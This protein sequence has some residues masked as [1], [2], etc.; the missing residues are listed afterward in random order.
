MTAEAMAPEAA[1]AA[2]AGAAATDALPP[3]FGSVATPPKAAFGAAAA[4]GPGVAATEAPAR[5]AQTAAQ[6]PAIASGAQ[7]AGSPG[8]E[9]AATP[10]AA[11]VGLG[12]AVNLALAAELE[13]DPKVLVM[14]EDVGQLGGVFRVTEGLAQRFGKDRVRDT[15]LGEAGIVGTAIGL[16][17]RGYRPVCEIQFDGFVFPAF[18]QIT[19][20]LAK[21]R[22]RSRGRLRVPLT[23]RIPFGGGIGAIEHHSES[24]EALLAHTAG[25]RV[26]SPATP[27]DAYT[28]TRAAIRC[29]DPVIV[30]EP[31]AR[32][33]S[34]G[35]VLL[36]AP[37]DGSILETAR[38]ARALAGDGV[39]AGAGPG[40]GVEARAAVTI[41][42][43]GPAVRPAEA[44][45]ELLAGEGVQAEVID[46]RAI[47]P[48][49]FDTLEASV[50]RT[51][52]LVVVHE[53]P[54]FFGAGAEI[55]A[56][57]AERCFYLLEAP[58]LRVGGHHLPYPPAL[59]EREYLPS[60]ERIAAAARRAL[61]F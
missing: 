7:V 44:A 29:P 13:A 35:P 52:R 27:Q 54:V 20:Q 45:A 25:L 12:K 10:G 57:I 47:S 31:K 4:A 32:Y 37:A 1:S 17:L 3:G 51:G 16:A 2:G 11:V 42:A 41:A 55:A 39:G 58:V 34:K 30:L 24:P 61:A 46:L 56:R 50:L 21:L 22:S 49:D 33:W 8:A 23:I 14:G 6:P 36:E 18:S 19:T 40:S 48:I 38:V 9:P 59:V 26:V 28:M 53:A 60:P 15:P 5:A 43:Y